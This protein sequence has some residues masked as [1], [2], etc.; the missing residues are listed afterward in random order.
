VLQNAFVHAFKTG[1]T[2]GATVTFI[3]TAS[4]ITILN[5]SAAFW[6]LVFGALVSALLERADYRALRKAA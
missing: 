5:V 2:L 1:F 6:G 3:V 4:Q